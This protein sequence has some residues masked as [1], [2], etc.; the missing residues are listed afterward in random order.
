MYAH[1]ALSLGKLPHYVP[2]TGVALR[3]PLLFCINMLL[4]ASGV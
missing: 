1:Y 4:C 2:H 3:R